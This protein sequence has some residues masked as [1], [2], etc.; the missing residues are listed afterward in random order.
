MTKKRTSGILLSVLV[1]FVAARLLA[2]APPDLS[3][4]WI[5]VAEKSQGVPTVPRIYNTT[6]APAASKDL[7]ITQTPA[8]VRVKIG[9]VELVYRLEGPEGNISADGRAG[10]PVGKAAWE[11]AAL[12]ATLTQE[13]FSPAD[14]NYIK[15]PIRETY[16]LSD[17]LLIVERVRTHLGGKTDTQKLVYTKSA[18]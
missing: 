7:Q 13:V 8:A 11:G 10:F 16:T 18:S 4:T 14:S 12:V 5:F 15:V 6:G 17:G 2:Q 9:G 3:G 1:L